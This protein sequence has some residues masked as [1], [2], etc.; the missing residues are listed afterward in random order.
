MKKNKGF[1]LIELLAVIVILAIVIIIA[2]PIFTNQTDKA[3]ES[4]YKEQ[5]NRILAAAKSWETENTNVLPS[6]SDWNFGETKPEDFDYSTLTNLEVKKVSVT[7]LQKDG[8]LKNK[9]VENPIDKEDTLNGNIVIYYSAPYKQYV[10]L[11]CYTQ[12]EY[13]AYGH[14]YYSEKKYNKEVKPICSMESI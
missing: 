8:F 9:D 7:K 2:I 6:Q 1:T 10:T 4:L 12:E 5:V 14:Y 13:E 3:K 11:Y